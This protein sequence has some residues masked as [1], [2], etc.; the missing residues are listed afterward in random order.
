[1]TDILSITPIIISILA[2]A[3]SIFSYFHARKTQEIN[4]KWEQIRTSREIFATVFNLERRLLDLGAEQRSTSNED[5]F[6]LISDRAYAIKIAM[7]QHADYFADLVLTN[8]VGWDVVKYYITHLIRIG[9]EINSLDLQVFGPNLIKLL[10]TFSR[11]TGRSS[12]DEF[13]E[14]LTRGSK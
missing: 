10:D 6:S 3:V 5:E 11:M 8:R 7:A 9:G 2:L 14:A 12:Y 13:Y 4:S 1:M